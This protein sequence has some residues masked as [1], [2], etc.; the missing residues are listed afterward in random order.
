MTTR[1]G[2]QSLLLETDWATIADSLSMLFYR[3]SLLFC[4][5]MV[6]GRRSRIL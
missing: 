2:L 4:G 1:I 5:A 3:R 6:H